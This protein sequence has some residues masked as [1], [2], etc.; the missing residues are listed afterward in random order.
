VP[1][2]T[3]GDYA[4]DLITFV[5]VCWSVELWRDKNLFMMISETVPELSTL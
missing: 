5:L 3:A 2:I 4:F 1:L